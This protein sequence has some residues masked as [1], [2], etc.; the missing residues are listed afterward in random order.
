MIGPDT[1][2]RDCTVG[3]GATVVRTHGSERRI[4]AGATV[5]PFAYLRPGHPAGGARQ[6][7]HVRRGE[8]RRHRGRPKV[9]HL[10]YVGD[11]TIGEH[12]NIG[13][14]TVFV[15]Y[16]GV[17]KHHTVVGSHVRTGSD[18]MFVAPV[19]DRRR[20]LHRRPGR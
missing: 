13:A 10:S 6:D 17:R 19:L 18:N 16:D 15:N 4:G 3:A 5:G 12:S 20:R 1:T 2:L 9:P 7:R 14:A 11:A 8:E